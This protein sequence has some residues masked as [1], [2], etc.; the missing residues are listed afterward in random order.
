V[1]IREFDAVALYDAIDARR[2]ADGLS[3]QGVADAIWSLSSELNAE[4][5]ARGLRN[6]PIVPSTLRAIAKRQN[7][8]CQH[9]VFILRWLQRTPESFL[10]GAAPDAGRSLP[11]CGPDRRLR[12]NLRAMYE[13]VDEGRAARDLTWPATAKQLRC[14]P[15]QLTGLKSAKSA[16]NIKLAM[17]IT[18]WVQRPA[19]DFIDPARW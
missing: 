8:S 5:D 16:T 3:W 10:T 19:A 9:A 7:A 6:H 15:G 12:W 11:A 14:S 17:R 4:R 2:V 1:T 18:Q 13:A